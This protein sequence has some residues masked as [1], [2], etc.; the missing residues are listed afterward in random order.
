M[1]QAAS[2]LTAFSSPEGRLHDRTHMFVAATLYT[3]ESSCPVHIRNMS[4]SGALIEGAVLPEMDA[5]VTLRRGSLEARAKIVWRTDRRAGVAFSG[6]IQVAE[7]M[8]RNP[9]SHQVEVDEIVRGIRAGTGRQHLH[10]DT[11]PPA[12]TNQSAEVE[13]LALKAE[14]T[15]LENGL[16][17]DAQVAAKHPEIQLLDNALQRVARLLTAA[18]LPRPRSIV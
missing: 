6:S 4:L 2:T 15:R 8:S 17:G 9:P 1:A 18:A 13:L 5:P 7:W 16:T 12:A 11:A 10:A 3:N 14:L